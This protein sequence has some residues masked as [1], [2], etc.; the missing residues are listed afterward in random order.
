MTTATVR[1]A[2]HGDL[3]AISQ[4]EQASFA[5]PWPIDTFETYLDA[6]AFLVAT[7]DDD[8]IV[9]FI[10]GDR[11]VEHDDSIGHIK[12][13]AVAPA[14]RRQGIGRQLLTAAIARLSIAGAH[15]VTL[16]V[17]ASNDAAKALYQAVGF[18][19]AGHQAAYYQD[20]EDAILMLR[21]V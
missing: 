21:D 20:G 11:L 17:R 4:I 1:S 18:Q 12:D 9:G 14:Y 8:T 2:R 13:F 15:V 16:E 3:V 19:Q 6:A 7:T 10:L 5:N